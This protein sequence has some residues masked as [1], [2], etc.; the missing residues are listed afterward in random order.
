MTL[1]AIY[2]RFLRP[3]EVLQNNKRRLYVSVVINIFN[4]IFKT[5]HQKF[6][7]QTKSFITEDGG[8]RG[9]STSNCGRPRPFR[10]FSTLEKQTAA[11]HIPSYIV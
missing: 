11:H 5:K 4:M 10:Y 9:L 6:M 8:D 3:F 2:S 7:Q 1:K